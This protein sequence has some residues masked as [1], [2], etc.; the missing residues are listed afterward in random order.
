MGS[1]TLPAFASLSTHRI[2]LTLALALFA[3]IL[4]ASMARAAGVD[5]CT[6]VPMPTIHSIVGKNVPVVRHSPPAE[7]DGV[8][9]SSCVFQS[10]GNAGFLTLS[11]FDL[12][13]TAQAH[14]DTYA[15]GVTAAG[16]KV[17]PEQVGSETASFIT[18]IGGTGQ[19]FVVHGNVLVAAAVTR[20]KEGTTKWQLDHSRDLAAAATD[21]LGI[22]PAG[23]SK[24][25]DTDFTVNMCP[26]AAMFN[27]VL[28]ATKPSLAQAV[29][30][31][32]P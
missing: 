9:R 25:A 12:A 8:T 20:K 27:S 10:S 17:E 23:A 24:V 21:G 1:R 7:K 31:C 14:L 18:P 13:A 3:S 11:V 28:P 22:A 19:M 4:G 15:Q 2:A 5:A 30:I 26:M 16:G 6:L 29:W 32:S